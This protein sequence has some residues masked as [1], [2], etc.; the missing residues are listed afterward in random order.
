[1][2]EINWAKHALNCVKVKKKMKKKFFILKNMYI[3]SRNLMILFFRQFQ[4]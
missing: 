1:M 3:C 4:W 2:M